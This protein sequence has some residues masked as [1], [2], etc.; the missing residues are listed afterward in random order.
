MILLDLVE[1]R[2]E[3]NTWDTGITA[4]LVERNILKCFSSQLLQVLHMSLSAN[5]FADSDPIVKFYLLS[6]MILGMSLVMIKKPSSES[7][8]CSNF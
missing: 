1:M 2:K 8:D 6:S 4:G 7:R 3:E 5:V